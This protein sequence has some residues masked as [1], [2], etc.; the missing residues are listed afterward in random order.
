MVDHIIEQAHNNTETMHRL[1]NDPRTIIVRTERSGDATALTVVICLFFVFLFGLLFLRL[2]DTDSLTRENKQILDS[3]RMTIPGAD[4]TR[5]VQPGTE[6]MPAAP[7]TRESTP[8]TSGSQPVSPPLSSSAGSPS[9][10]S[11]AGS[12]STPADSGSQ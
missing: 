7:L 12:Q 5:Q 11:P 3:L 4:S 9:A 8:A 6:N 2:N 10:P 1:N